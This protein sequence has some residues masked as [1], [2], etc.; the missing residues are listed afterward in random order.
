MAQVTTPTNL[1]DQL[2]ERLYSE[3]RIKRGTDYAIT[4]KYNNY[5]LLCNTV[6]VPAIQAEA[7]RLGIHHFST[8]HTYA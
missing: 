3:H 1:L 6:W 8:V 7:D 5:H 2:S 4:F